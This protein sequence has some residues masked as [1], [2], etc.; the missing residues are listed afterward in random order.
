MQACDIRECDQECAEVLQ[1]I[2]VVVSRLEVALS[3]T[4]NRSVLDV[5]LVQ[6]QQDDNEAQHVPLVKF[7]VGVRVF[8][9]HLSEVA[10]TTN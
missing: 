4:S 8:A 6:R 1:E 10:K 2:I 7:F 9:E 5:K 3:V